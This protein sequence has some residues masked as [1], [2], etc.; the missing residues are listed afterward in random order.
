MRDRIECTLL[1]IALT[2]F[3]TLCASLPAEAGPPLICHP[4]EIDGA[5]SL[6]WDGSDGFMDVDDDYP[7]KHLVADVDSLLGPRTPVLV[8]METIRRATIYASKDSGRAKELLSH[9]AAAAE[10]GDPLATFDYGYA[11]ETYRHAPARMPGKGL[12]GYA[13]VARAADA[14]DDPAMQLALAIISVHPTRD[15]LDRH[16]ANA[17]AG[18]EPGSPLERNIV[19]QF[20]GRGGSIAALR[21]RAGLSAGR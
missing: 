6:P 8:R 19:R 12:D 3:L 20:E 2:G 9:L 18:A 14:T 16:L 21:K 15:S 17:L 10:G 7:V 11:I 13:L 1:G 5:E 4:I